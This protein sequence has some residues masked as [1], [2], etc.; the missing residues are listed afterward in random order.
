MG[1]SSCSHT[2]PGKIPVVLVHGTG[3]S[4]AR[5]DELANELLGDVRIRERYHNIK[6][7]DYRTVPAGEMKWSLS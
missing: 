2:R 6:N 4:T 5:W 1:S 3:S 7:F